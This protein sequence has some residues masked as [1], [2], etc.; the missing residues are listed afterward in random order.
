[1]GNASNRT[2]ADPLT[3]EGNAPQGTSRPNR[4]ARPRRSMLTPRTMFLSAFVFM[5]QMFT[6]HRAWVFLCIA[7]VSFFHQ[8]FTEFLVAEDGVQLQDSNG[9]ELLN[10]EVSWTLTR[11]SVLA[12]TRNK[13]LISPPGGKGRGV[14]LRRHQKE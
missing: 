9:V 3:G 7:Y 8:I 11:A 4:R 6:R 10:R 12:R 1:M 14:V 5:D 13:S 2:R